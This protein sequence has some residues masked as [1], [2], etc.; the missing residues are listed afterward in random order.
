MHA[1]THAS[2]HVIMCVST[3]VSLC[4]NT[5]VSL[6]VSTCVCVSACA[7]WLSS[8]SDL[9]ARDSRLDCWLDLI[10]LWHFAPGQGTLPTRALS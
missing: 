4:V 9:Q 7:L 10:V 3:L 2:T 5:S 6:C 8:V 1:S